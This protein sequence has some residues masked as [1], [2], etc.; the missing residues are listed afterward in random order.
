MKNN[1]RAA[2]VSNAARRLVS[3]LVMSRALGPQARA[4]V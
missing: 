2:A 4:G 1:V 3:V